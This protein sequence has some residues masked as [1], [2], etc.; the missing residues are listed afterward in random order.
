MLGF[1]G[2]E[3]ALAI[4]T[5]IQ[6]QHDGHYLEDSSFFGQT[7]G[8]RQNLHYRLAISSALHPSSQKS[9]ADHPA[10]HENAPNGDGGIHST[11]DITHPSPLLSSSI[12]HTTISSAK[13]KVWGGGG[14]PGSL[15]VRTSCL[16]SGHPR[17]QTR[18][19]SRTITQSTTTDDAS[20]YDD[21]SSS[22][23]SPSRSQRSPRRAGLSLSSAPSHSSW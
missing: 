1:S 11:Q 13:S 16:R 10:S 17:R 15:R 9:V 12:F 8:H 14:V 20:F 23:S 18:G 6:Q 19:M 21:T 5:N 4:H 3:R 22:S 7:G 2:P